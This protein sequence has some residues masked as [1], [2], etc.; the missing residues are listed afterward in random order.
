LESVIATW[1]ILVE[2]CQRYARQEALRVP[3]DIVTR[4]E[5]R[6]G[7]VNRD[8]VVMIEIWL[9]VEKAIPGLF[10]LGRPM[11]KP[12]FSMVGARRIVRRSP[13]VINGFLGSLGVAVCQQVAEIGVACHIGGPDD[14]R[15]SVC[16]FELCPDDELDPCLLG[17][18]MSP[19]D[20]RECG[21]VGDRQSLVAELGR[22]RDELLRMRGTL[23]K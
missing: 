6:A 1:S 4:Q 18:S 20:S 15:R 21:A 19:H 14:Q 3:S 23:E 5:T 8:V 10:P 13:V 9:S 7:G 11:E 2:R 16:R 22:S 17:G 12:R